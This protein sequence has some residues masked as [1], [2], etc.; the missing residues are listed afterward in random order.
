MTADQNFAGTAPALLAPTSNG[1]EVADRYRAAFIRTSAIV[2][3]LAPAVISVALAAIGQGFRAVL[4]APVAAVGYAGWRLIRAGKVQAGFRVFVYG[5]WFCVILSATMVNG[6]DG[7]VV[8]AIALILAVAGCLTDKRSALALTAATPPVLFVLAYAQWAGWPLP[9]RIA[10]SPFYV[11]SIQTCIMVAAGM[12]GYFAAETVRAQLNGLRRLGSQLKDT[13]AQLTLRDEELRRNDAE[14]RRNDAELRALTLTLEQRVAERT[15]K[16]AA[17]V[18]DLEEFASSIAHNLR[19]PLRAI[20]ANARMVQYDDSAG[21]SDLARRRLAGVERNALVMAQLIDG[22]LELARVKRVE[23]ARVGINMQTLAIVAVGSL[24]PLYHGTNVEVRE[25]PTAKGDPALIRQVFRNLIE[26][27]L[28]YSSRSARS[29]VIVD[30][31]TEM[32]AWF[33]RDNGVGFDMS[34][35]TNLF[36]NF[37]RLHGSEYEGTGI[38]LAIAKSIIERHGGRIWAESFPNGGATFYFTLG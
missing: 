33:V 25:M 7:P 5:S 37:E 31:D 4:A 6:I 1:F 3:T 13:V 14:L 24:R 29:K 23:P 38:G 20:H 28:K 30:W 12:L 9:V 19:T 11:A 26:N 35:S 18:G 8:A 15:A 22:L 2:L 16:L 34:H 27:A 17:A 10:N 21:L 32:S 36:G